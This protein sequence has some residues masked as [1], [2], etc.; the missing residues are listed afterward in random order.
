MGSRDINGILSTESSEFTVH[1]CLPMARSVLSCRAG[2]G[3][4]HSAAL[5]APISPASE[6]TPSPFLWDEGVSRV[7]DLLRTGFRDFLN[8]AGVSGGG[9]SRT[10]CPRKGTLVA[11]SVGLLTSL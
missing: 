6:S 4:V 11:T 10:A 1:D 3:M 8:T 5:S 7:L 2:F 9:T